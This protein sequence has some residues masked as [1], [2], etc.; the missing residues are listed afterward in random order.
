MKMKKKY[1]EKQDEKATLIF[2]PLKIH[3]SSKMALIN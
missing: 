2:I 3:L 1:E